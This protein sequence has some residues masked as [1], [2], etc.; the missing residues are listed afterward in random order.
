M[1]TLRETQMKKLHRLE[2]CH[3]GSHLW[4]VFQLQHIIFNDL[5]GSIGLLYE[6]NV[7]LF[8]LFIK[9]VFYLAVEVLF[10]TSE[11]H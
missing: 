2:T 8:Y 1:P 4:N 6:Y 10:F 9:L 11:Q 3:R 7:N 5:M